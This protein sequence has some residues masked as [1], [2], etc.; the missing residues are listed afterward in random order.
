LRTE[1]AGQ[2]TRYDAAT[3]AAQRERGGKRVPLGG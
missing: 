1:T 3:A 2:R